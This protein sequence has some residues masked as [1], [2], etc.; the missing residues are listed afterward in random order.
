VARFSGYAV[1][2]WKSRLTSFQP[3]DPNFT[4]NLFE[5]GIARHKFGLAG[6]RPR[7]GKSVDARYFPIDVV[8][9]NL[10]LMQLAQK[11]RHR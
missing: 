9:K 10:S 4:L 6:L 8:S 3:P 2:S 11:L 1:D 7:R 5:P